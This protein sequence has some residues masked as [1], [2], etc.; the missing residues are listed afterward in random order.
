MSGT[1]IP[2]TPCSSYAMSGTDHSAWCRVSPYARG[3]RCPVLRSGMLVPAEASAHDAAAPV[4][5]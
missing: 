5:S 3:R 1:D 4:V 2:Y